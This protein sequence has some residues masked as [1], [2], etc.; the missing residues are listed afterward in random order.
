MLPVYR[1]LTALGGPLVR[2]YLRRRLARGKEDG[3]RFSE[4]TGLASRPRPQGPLVWVHAASVGES[5]SAVPLI[6]RLREERPALSVLLTTG[7]VSSARLMSERLPEG[8][9]HQYVPVDLAACV[10]RFLGHWRP[11]LALWMESEFW[12]NLVAEAAARGIPLVLVNGRMSPRSYD[13]W[14]RL[15]GLISRLL[16]GFPLC[17]AQSEEDARR[18]ARLGARRVACVGNLKFAS[19]PL[20][21]DEGELAR[22]AEALAAR[23]RWLAA[24][25][26]AGE[27]ELAGR[28]HAGLA[29]RHPGLLTLIAPRH[30]ERG[31]EIAAALRAAGLAVALRSRG[32]AVAR[33]TGVYVAD[34]MGE[35]G[36]F[37]RLAPIAFVGKSLVPLGG[38]NPLEAAILDC[39]ILFGPHTTN[40]E[41]LARGLAAAGAAEV[42]ADEAALEGAVDRLLRDAA[43]RGRMAARAAAFA[44][45]EAGVLERVL[46]E[47]APFLD[48]AE[49]DSDGHAG[50]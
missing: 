31:P 25:T 19:P 29:A 34:T 40:F 20:P 39:A 47:L 6:R 13:G 37:Y 27:E 41:E 14:R 16:E 2:L 30:P 43:A 7:T 8:A 35:L 38:Q 3:A 28:V 23:P 5:L 36:L 33:D 45:A 42:V 9:L 4:R 12:P 15:P 50:A 48:A 17:L 11:S 44:G 1:A 24:S 32:D 10:R 49:R 46:K 22:L 18:L 21:A 26:H